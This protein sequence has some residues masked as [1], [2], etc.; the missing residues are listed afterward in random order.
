[1]EILIIGLAVVVAYCFASLRVVKEYERGVAFF[2]GRCIGSTFTRWRR[3]PIRKT[4]VP[5]SCW[6]GN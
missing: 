3:S 2:L 4:I 5:A 6:P 1:M